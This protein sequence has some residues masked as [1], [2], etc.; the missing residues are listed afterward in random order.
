MSGYRAVLDTCVI[1]AGLYSSTGASHA[2]LGALLS[3]NLKLVLSPTL[4]FEYEDILR[5]KQE[6]LGLSHEEIEVI[7]NQFCAAAEC[8]RV[9]FLWRPRLR[10]AADDHLVELAFAAGGVPVVTHNVKHFK[11]LEDLGIQVMTPQKLLKE[12]L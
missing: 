10:D 6:M 3:G 5:R 1:I 12:I 11:D 9:N 7:L 2:A 4:L 8:R